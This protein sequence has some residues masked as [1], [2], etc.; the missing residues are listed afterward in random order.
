MNLAYLIRRERM[1]VTQ[2]EM[3]V[4]RADEDRFLGEFRVSAPEDANDVFL[5]AHDAPNVDAHCHLKRRAED[6]GL[7][8]HPLIDGCL[9]VGKLLARTGQP[10][11][12]TVRGKPEVHD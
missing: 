1:P 10:R 2:P 9:Q 8:L 11:T 7:R 4:V 3:V 5:P 12:V 6:K